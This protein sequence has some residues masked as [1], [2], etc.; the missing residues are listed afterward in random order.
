MLV[1]LAAGIWIL[2]QQPTPAPEAI[3]PAAPFSSS[4]LTERSETQER[5]LGHVEN[6]LLEDRLDEASASI[7]AARKAGV[8]GSRIAYLTAQLAKSRDRIKAAAAK[9][10]PKSDARAT[11]AAVL[12]QTPVAMADTSASTVVC[13]PPLRAPSP[14]P[15][16]RAIGNFSPLPTS[17]P[18][19]RLKINY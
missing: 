14:P 18:M 1:A 5:L 15:I 10:R 4:P 16:S 8:D 11:E 12:S 2:R 17:K 13:W 7:A 3:E 9:A 6:A 19:Q